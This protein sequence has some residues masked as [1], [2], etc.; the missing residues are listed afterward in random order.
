MAISTRQFALLATLAM[1]TGICRAGEDIEWRHRATQGAV[2]LTANPLGVASRTAF[3]SARGFAAEVIRPYAD[4][5]GFSF[6]MQ[7]D[8]AGTLS[9]R[10][11][12]WRAVGAEGGAVRLRLPAE[13]DLQWVAA[14]VPDAARIAFR[15]AQ[16]QAENILEPGDWIMGMA[17][18][19]TPLPGSFRLVARYHDEKGGHEI[20]LDQLVCS[21]DSVGN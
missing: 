5:C 14:Q 2:T 8:G 16:F 10:L 20:V 17:T 3:Y 21:G 13:W 9:T 15:W 19:E 7:N 18:L 12:D 6:G 4:A 11:A 1:L